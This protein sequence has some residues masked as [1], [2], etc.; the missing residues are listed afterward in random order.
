MCACITR[1]A[2]SL[3]P[4][5]FFIPLLAQQEDSP[6]LQKTHEQHKDLGWYNRPG[7]S[8]RQALESS[9][10][11]SVTR[12]DVVDRGDSGGGR[13][14]S[15]QSEFA[16]AVCEADAVVIGE[17]RSA[18]S[19]LSRNETM[20]F[21]DYLVSP[22]EILKSSSEVP[23]VNDTPFSL[24]RPGGEVRLEI[25]TI[26]Q[27]DHDYPVLEVRKQYLFLL[28]NLPDS[29]SFKSFDRLGTYRV[30]TGKALLVGKSV[31]EAHRRASYL[32]SLSLNDLHNTIG[33]ALKG[34]G[35]AK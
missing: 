21:T 31:G 34:C 14:A 19:M 15:P 35:Q 24:T 28:S 6:A 10:T 3:I 33:S 13:S 20:V 2:F 23:I 30:D 1:V 9:S 17:V 7:D 8:L 16:S 32:N 4:L 29:K 26:Q 18:V 5:L 27:K 22:D 25:G 11:G 12:E